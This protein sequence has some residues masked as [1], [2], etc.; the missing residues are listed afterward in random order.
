MV[1][2]GSF[3]NVFSSAFNRAGPM[4]FITNA[5]MLQPVHVHVLGSN[6]PLWSLSY[7]VWF[8][9]WFGIVAFGFQRGPR[10]LVLGIVFATLGLLLFNWTALI[11]LTIWCF[12]ALAYQWTGWRRSIRLAL[13]AFLVSLAVSLSSRLSLLAVPF[14]LSDF[15][16]GL[17]FA[18]L[19]ALMKGRSYRLLAT[20][21]KL[22]QTLSQFS[23]S[24]YVIHFPTMLCLLAVFVELAGLSAVLKQGFV[25]SG[26][27]LFVYFA[28]AASTF[29]FAFL[30]SRLFEAQ[31]GVLRRWL[32]A[33]F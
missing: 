21:E 2:T 4:E 23:Y 33:R 25:P 29:I 16:V 14:K 8:Y 24:L 15:P 18:W 11:G 19:L 22:N 31:T 17:S 26:L 5:V 10:S 20:T 28:T 6:V 13:L 32:K 1:R 12:G 27:T 7:E 3:R 9:V 30:F